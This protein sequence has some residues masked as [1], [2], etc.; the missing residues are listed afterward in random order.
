MVIQHACVHTHTIIVHMGHMNKTDHHIIWSYI[1]Q[2]H[3][4]SYVGGLSVIFFAMMMDGLKTQRPVILHNMYI[5][6]FNTSTSLNNNITM[7]LRRAFD[8]TFWAVLVSASISTRVDEQS[9]PQS[10]RAAWCPAD[11]GNPEGERERRAPFGMGGG[12][13]G[14]SRLVRPRRQRGQRAGRSHGCGRGRSQTRWSG[15]CRGW[16]GLLSEG[17]G[18]EEGEEEGVGL[19]EEGERRMCRCRQ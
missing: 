3:N 5:V 7:F 6:I 4:R 18:E 14:Q 10:L 13:R 15:T 12:R 16:R 2:S 8:G 11:P 1:L 17:Q 9:S 19:R